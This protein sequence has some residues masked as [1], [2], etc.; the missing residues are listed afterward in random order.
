MI[1]LIGR[2][3]FFLFAPL[4]GSGASC[5]YIHNDEKLG[6]WLGTFPVVLMVKTLPANAGVARDWEKSPEVGNGNPLQYCCLENPMD[7]EA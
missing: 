2:D 3:F 6:T 1:F 4:T 5:R 7:R